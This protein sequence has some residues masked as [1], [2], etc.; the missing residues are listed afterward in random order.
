MLARTTAL[1]VLVSTALVCGVLG[2]T[3]IA[4]AT[5]PKRQDPSMVANETALIDLDKFLEDLD[6]LRAL[7]DTLVDSYV[8][9][10]RKAIEVGDYRTAEELL[11]ELKEYLNTRYGGLT[12]NQTSDL[13]EA[14]ATIMSTESINEKGAVVDVAELLSMYGE[15]TDN[16]DLIELAKKFRTDPT[17]LN[18]LDLETVNK[19][20]KTVGA[21]QYKP[22]NLEELTSEVPR[23][24]SPTKLP[25]VS[26]L[27]KPPQLPSIGGG[28]VASAPI[29]SAPSSAGF[30]ESILYISLFSLIVFAIIW[31][32]RTI[33]S[34]AGKYFSK[35]IARTRIALSSITHGSVNDPVIDAYRRL[36]LYLRVR[37]IKR[38]P[39]ET[40]REVVRKISIE[41]LK[42]IAWDVT[43]VYE[44]RVYGGKSI[45]GKEVS[46]IRGLVQR[47]LR[48]F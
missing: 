29:V 25:P 47:V 32:R 6:S 22:I 9:A 33:S 45:G 24:L 12:L 31:Y 3:S 16:R 14:L 18:E 17:A 26:R 7:N 4:Y 10:I 30:V 44:E 40:P 43:R 41:E 42:R 27:P 34:Y 20:L 5:I 11:K 8:A 37:G 36:L 46:R 1:L 48:G 13:A 35:A 38:E 15:L 28:A 23:E 19:I 39:C 21:Q 2:A